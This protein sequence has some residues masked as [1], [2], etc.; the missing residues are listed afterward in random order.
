MDTL[1][2]RD[3]GEL[4]PFFDGFITQAMALTDNWYAQE[5]S[6]VSTSASD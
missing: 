2:T 3:V 6:A 4:L 1:G 5:K